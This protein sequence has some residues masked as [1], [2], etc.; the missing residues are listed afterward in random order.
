MMIVI[1]SSK[2]CSEQRRL[3]TERDVQVLEGL[4]DFDGIPVESYL[5]HRPPGTVTDH[6]GCR[7]FD[8]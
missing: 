7:L 4:L 6:H 5:W 8:I 1:H 3:R 2:V